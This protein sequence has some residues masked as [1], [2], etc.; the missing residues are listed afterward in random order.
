MIVVI[1]SAVVSLAPLQPHVYMSKMQIGALYHLCRAVEIMVI[2]MCAIY[3]HI[4]ATHGLVFDLPVMLRILQ[5][6]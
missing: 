3:Y 6:N 2:K 5:K 1:I 4:A